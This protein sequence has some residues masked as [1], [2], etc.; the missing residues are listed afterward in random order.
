MSSVSAAHDVQ[1]EP[2]RQVCYRH[3]DRIDIAGHSAGATVWHRLRC[4]RNQVLSSD[5]RSGAHR[6][7]V[8]IVDD[9]VFPDADDADHSALYPNWAEAEEL[10]DDEARERRIDAAPHSDQLVQTAAKRRH[11]ADAQ[12]AR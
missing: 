6:A 5:T 4:L 1:A 11:Q 8:W 3:L 9:T 2:G 10:G 12:N 7:L